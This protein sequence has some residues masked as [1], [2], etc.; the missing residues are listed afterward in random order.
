MKTA[1]GEWEVSKGR[2]RKKMDEGKDGVYMRC[3][4]LALRRFDSDLETYSREYVAVMI[5]IND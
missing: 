2:I 3:T 4:S 1:Q 5:D